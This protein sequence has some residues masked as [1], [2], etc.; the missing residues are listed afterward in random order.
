MWPVIPVPKQHGEGLVRALATSQHGSQ[1]QSQLAVQLSHEKTHCSPSLHC[2]PSFQH[3]CLWGRTEIPQVTPT[4]YHAASF[5]QPNLSEQALKG[6]VHTRPAMAA[7]WKSGRMQTR[8]CLNP[9]GSTLFLHE[10]AQGKVWET[11]NWRTPVSPARSPLDG[12][13]WELRCQA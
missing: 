7:V 8:S 5:L 3:M 11:L 9:F 4:P 2:G 13:T 10:P 1:M 6:G 12:L